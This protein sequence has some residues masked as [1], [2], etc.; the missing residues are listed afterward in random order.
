[1]AFYCASD[2]DDDALSSSSADPSDALFYGMGVRFADTAA[3]IFYSKENREMTEAAH[4]VVETKNFD[5]PS[6]SQ[7]VTSPQLKPA[8]R[9]VS[10]M[11]HRMATP[12]FILAA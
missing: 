5:G 4:A 1:M 9:S 3:V 6:R 8:S 11:L 2:C 10:E 7:T 12:L